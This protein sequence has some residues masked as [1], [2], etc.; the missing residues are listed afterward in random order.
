[1]LSQSLG[2]VW[3]AGDTQ[4]HTHGHTLRCARA[5]GLL[6]RPLGV[7]TALSGTRIG[8]EREPGLTA[9]TP[10]A[11]NPTV[12]APSSSHLDG[13]G[14]RSAVSVR[15][16]LGNSEKHTR[17]GPRGQ[18]A[19]RLP[20][21]GRARRRA[22]VSVHAPSS[23]PRGSDPS[24]LA[25]KTRQSGLSPA[26]EGASSPPASVCGTRES[27]ARP[28]LLPGVTG[29]R[30]ATRQG[31]GQ[32]AHLGP[33]GA[34]QQ[35]P[36]HPLPLP[37]PRA[38]RA[39]PAARGARIPALR[40]GLGLPG[41]LLPRARLQ[42]LPPARLRPPEAPPAAR[43]A[44][45]PSRAPRAD[46][47]P[48]RPPSELR[49]VGERGARV[50]QRRRWVQSAEPCVPARVGHN[51]PAAR[52]C[53]LLPAP[54]GPPPLRRRP[55]RAAE[56]RGSANKLGSSPGRAQVSAASCRARDGAP[57]SSPGRARVSRPP[58]P[59]RARAPA[60]RRPPP[61]PAA[62]GAPAWGPGSASGCCCP[63]PSCS[64]RRAAGP[65]RR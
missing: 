6:A 52:S 18:A 12:T 37:T 13:R 54:Q 57:R 20:P 10:W 53:R 16:R 19:G 62:P 46:L 24:L 17:A 42:W 64:T 1:M 39:A 11:R 44:Q 29:S 7:P 3:G 28:R 51:P 8:P 38:G 58:P 56:G 15:P 27:G 49:R 25:W 35:P 59:P 45:P 34:A 50:G 43:A 23:A 55:P 32:P 47:G 22:L 14:G 2:W 4:A 40:P 9:R 48:A 36:L 33:D 65:P 31:R 60:P 5:S 21:Q 30:P 61:V 26:G 63:P 41:P